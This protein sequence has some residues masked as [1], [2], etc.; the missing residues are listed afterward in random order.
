MIE[1]EWRGREAEREREAERGYLT[2][3]IVLCDSKYFSF[4]F[5]SFVFLAL[6]FDAVL[7]DTPRE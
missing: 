4:F 3:G 1:R 7:Q 5:V 6:F 2:H